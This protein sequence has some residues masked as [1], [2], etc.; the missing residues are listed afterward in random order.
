MAP[1]S[2]INATIDTLRAGVPLSDAEAR[3]KGKA[4]KYQKTK[5]QLPEHVVFLIE[6]E[7]AK[8]A[9][10]RQFKTHA[11]NKLYH[12]EADGSFSLNLKDPLFCEAKQDLSE[13]PRTGHA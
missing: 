3:D 9:Q 7:S 13:G 10:P 2:G 6:Q 11:I 12:K 5:D 1:G 4:L 8:A